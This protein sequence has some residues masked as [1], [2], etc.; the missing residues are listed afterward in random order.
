MPNNSKS[1]FLRM[2]LYGNQGV[3]Y[4]TCGHLLRENKS[5]RH[6]HRRQ[7]DILSI[8]N[9]VIKKGRPLGNRHGKTEAQKEH[10]IA[11]NL[12]KRC[13]KKNRKRIHD[14]FQKDLIFRDS[15][16]KIDRTEAKSIE[17]D[18]VA[19][20]DFT[21]HPSSEEFESRN[22]PMKLRSDFRE[23]LTKMHRL[24]RE[25]GEERLA[26]ILFWQ[27][28]KWHSSSSSSS[29]SWKQWNDH[30][31]SS[32]YF[33]FIVA[34]SFTADGNL[35]QPTGWSEQ[36]T[37]TRHIFSCL[38]ALMMLSHRTSSV[39]ACHTIHVSCACVFDLSST[40]FLHSTSS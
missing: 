16:L 22:A 7:L 21:Y 31:W 35:L 34:R 36:N 11:N 27:Y 40:L 13:I 6:F 24:H 37:L 3:V 20:K 26:P 12:R 29:T 30:W 4:R 2:L 18:E 25:S 5:C 14:R 39:C 33:E 15:Q 1:A 23:A 32:Y 9:Y 10:F 17:M 19:Q 28:Q 38:S 8:T